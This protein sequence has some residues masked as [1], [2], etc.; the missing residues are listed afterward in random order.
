MWWIQKYQAPT[1]LCTLG[2]PYDSCWVFEQFAVW[3]IFL[4]LRMDGLDKL[5][6]RRHVQQG[7]AYFR[8]FNKGREGKNEAFFS[9]NIWLCILFANLSWLESRG[10]LPLSAPWGGEKYDYMLFVSVT[11]GTIE[12]IK[13]LIREEK[14]KKNLTVGGGGLGVGLFTDAQALKEVKEQ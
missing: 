14:Q 11:W 2:Q 7:W 9:P 6:L 8:I 13:S 1:T 12:E 5:F 4:H 3:L 10:C